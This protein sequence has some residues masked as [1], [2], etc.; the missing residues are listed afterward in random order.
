MEY[1][2]KII[3]ELE[4]IKN[5]KVDYIDR[6][7]IDIIYNDDNIEEE[8]L[9]EIYEILEK[10]YDKYYITSIEN[11]KNSL[12]I[13]FKLDIGD[14]YDSEET[15]YQREKDHQEELQFEAHREKEKGIY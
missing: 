14:D 10:I 2:N 11:K 5:L 6:G 3:G 9:L 15:I 4:D 7:E 13:R 12:Y 8:L 1:Y